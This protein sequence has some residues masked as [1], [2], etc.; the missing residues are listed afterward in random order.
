MMQNATLKTK[1]E[2][3][4]DIQ[5][6][7][8]GWQRLA[9][10][11]AALFRRCQLFKP[12]QSLPTSLLLILFFLSLILTFSPHILVFRLTR[13]PLCSSPLRPFL[14]P[15]P[16]LLWLLSHSGLPEKPSWACKLGSYFCG[17]VAALNKIAI[18]LPDVFSF[19]LSLFLFFFSPFLQNIF[20]RLLAESEHCYSV[21]WCCCGFRSKTKWRMKRC[22]SPIRGEND[23]T[24]RGGKKTSVAH[25]NSPE[26]FP[27]SSGYNCCFCVFVTKCLQVS[28]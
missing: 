10:K 20:H 1:R 19:S 12:T 2:G 11:A 27:V 7:G 6:S 9:P 14:P 17:D 25:I 24:C 18:V 16:A 3:R 4:A 8:A 26:W 28:S 15:P 5:A 13:I 22:P 21:W 23:P